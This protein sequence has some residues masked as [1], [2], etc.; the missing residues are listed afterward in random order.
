VEDNNK[1]NVKIIKIIKREIEKDEKN[2]KALIDM[3]N[4]YYQ[5]KDYNE[6]LKYYEKVLSYDQKNYVAKI[7]ISN[8]YSKLKKYHLVEK[9]LKECIEISPEKN[10]AYFNLANNYKNI[11]KLELAKQYYIKAIKAKPDHTEAAYNLAEIYYVEKKYKNTISLGEQIIK[12]NNRIDC[13]MLMAMTYKKIGN[14]AEAKKYFSN[15]IKFRVSTIRE[16]RMQSTAYYEMG[17]WAI[18]FDR[19][20]EP[21]SLPS[22]IHEELCSEK[23]GI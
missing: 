8:I 13:H 20:K 14:S 22:E 7:N 10:Y 6:S 1:N 3:G 17:E 23:K 12:I 18:A 9:I 21:I 2:L 5:I 16:K 4:I 11:G 19:C 15:C